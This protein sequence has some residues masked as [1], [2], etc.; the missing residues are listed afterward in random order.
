MGAVSR[1]ADFMLAQL[2]SIGLKSGKYGGKKSKYFLNHASN[3]SPV[4]VPW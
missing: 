4:I 3:L 1:S 2:F